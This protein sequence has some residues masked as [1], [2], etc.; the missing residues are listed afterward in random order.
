MTINYAHNYI[1]NQVKKY[2]L[3]WGQGWNLS[4][5]IGKENLMVSRKVMFGSVAG[6][7]IAGGVVYSTVTSH[8]KDTTKN[9]T[10]AIVTGQGGVDDK[11]FNQSAWTGLEKWGKKN[12][13]TKGPNGYNYFESKTEA[14]FTTNFTQAVN[15]KYSMIAGI[16]Y[17]LHNATTDAAK[18]NPNTKFVLVDDIDTTHLKNIASV[19]FRSEQSSYLAGVAAATKAKKLGQDTIGFVGG[20]HGNII[21]AFEAGYTAGAKSVDP[22]INIDVQYVD[23]FSDSAKGNLVANTMIAKGE[24]IIFA[25]AGG[26]GKGVFTAAKNTDTKINSGDAKDKTWVIGVDMDQSA[27]G[28]YKTSDGKSD[29]FVLTSSITGV[30]RGLE[31]IADSAKDGNF[32]GG[33]TTAYG[34]KEGGVSITTKNLTSDEKSATEEASIKIVNNDIKVPA[35]PVGSKFN[36]KF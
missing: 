33:K 32:P 14:D 11:S 8:D 12:N 3:A 36:Q 22:D 16:G 4:D 23:S 25:A 5:L 29:N 1:R 13:L 26:S 15:A 10:V 19:M 31:L 30:G 18:K 7:L 6:L 24:H 20:M 9:F 2:I 27:D 17:S 28:N 34:L 21:D 35:H